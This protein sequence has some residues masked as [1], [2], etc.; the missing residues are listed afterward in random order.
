MSATFIAKAAL[1]PNSRASMAS[2][3][4]NASVSSALF[5]CKSRSAAFLIPCSSSLMRSMV[6]CFFSTSLRSASSDW[7][8]E[9]FVAKALLLSNSRSIMTSF[10]CMAVVI[11]AFFFFKSASAAFLISFSSSIRRSMIFC[12]WPNSWRNASSLAS[13]EWVFA[14]F[15]A[16]AVLLSNSRAIMTSFSCTAAVIAT[17]FC[18]KSASSA[19]LISFS[20][21]FRRS[22]AFCF[23]A[24]SLRN[25]CS[26][27]S[28]TPAV[29]AAFFCCKSA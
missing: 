14:A 19:F 29:I 3:C 23:C 5:F 9:A 6:F 7:V 25:A 4:C 12:F 21:S 18:C 17:V 1:L 8:F 11:A 22:M 16:K 20:S 10:C 15:L 26:S 2:F 28:C 24:T 13:S 27:F